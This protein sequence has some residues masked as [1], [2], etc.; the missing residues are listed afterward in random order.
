MRIIPDTCQAPIGAADMPC[1]HTTYAVASP[2]MATERERPGGIDVP[3]WW[4]A[5]AKAKR[6]EDE[7]SQE[8]LAEAV[9]TTM[10]IKVD[11]SRVSKCLRGITATIPLLDAISTALGIPPPVFVTESEQEARE[12]AGQQARSRARE[13]MLAEA[14]AR[15]K[16]NRAKALHLETSQT[17]GRNSQH[18]DEVERPPRPPGPRRGGGGRS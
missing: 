9:S 16:E 8:Q 4:M 17:E 15:Q 1:E 5:R 3:A 10:K 2:T 6:S 7:M 11:Q 13:R 12:L 18:G 14:D